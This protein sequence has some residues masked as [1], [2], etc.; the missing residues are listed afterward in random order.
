ML[1]FGWLSGIKSKPWVC[2]LLVWLFCPNRALLSVWTRNTLF[3][4]VGSPEVFSGVV[5]RF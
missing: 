5:E 3:S 1:V 2:Q 4:M